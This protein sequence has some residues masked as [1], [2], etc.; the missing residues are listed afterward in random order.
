M[1]ISL[2]NKL[3]LLLQAV[4]TNLRAALSLGT[5]LV[6]S[7]RNLNGHLYVLLPSEVVCLQSQ[8]EMKCLV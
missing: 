2:S 1:P 7:N 4:R 3:K 5:M 8:N 6:F